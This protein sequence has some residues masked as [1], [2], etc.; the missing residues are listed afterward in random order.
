[1]AA[2]LLGGCHRHNKVMGTTP[3]A[4]FEL[5]SAASNGALPDARRAVT[6]RTD[7]LPLCVEAWRAICS[8]GAAARYL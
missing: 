5:A 7:R 2:V 4:N 6:G 3:A 1:M 8:V